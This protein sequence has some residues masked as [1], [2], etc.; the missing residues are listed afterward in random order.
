MEWD[1]Q[2]A[3]KQKKGTGITKRNDKT[4]LQYIVI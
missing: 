1:P 2:K 4:L 3:K